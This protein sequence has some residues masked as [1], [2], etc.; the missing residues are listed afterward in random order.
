MSRPANNSNRKRA[1]LFFLVLGYFGVLGLA[2]NICV[3]FGWISARLPGL[4]GFT[5]R[6]EWALGTAVC[7]VF[8]W[9]IE[10]LGRGR[11]T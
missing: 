11:P 4:T 5:A 8:A 3:R 9:Y 1:G 2:F 7:F 10:R 6:W